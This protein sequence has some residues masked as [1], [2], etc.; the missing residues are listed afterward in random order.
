MKRVATLKRV[1]KRDLV[2]RRNIHEDTLA[3]ATTKYVGY[4]QCMEQKSGK[5]IDHKVFHGNTEEKLNRD[6][7]R[8][9][10]SMLKRNSKDHY[11]F[12]LRT[13]WEEDDSELPFF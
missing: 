1:A 11:E 7:D 8:Y 4:I 10:E 3:C 13:E 2:F 5:F 6:F 9:I 12:R